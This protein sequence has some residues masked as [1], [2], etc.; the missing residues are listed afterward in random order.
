MDTRPLSGAPW[1]LIMPEGL[2]GKLN[3]HLFSGDHDEHGAVIAAGLHLALDGSV[4]LLARDLYLAIDGSDY[5]PGTRGHRMLKREFIRDRIRSC[6]DEKLVYLAVHNH[7]PGNSVAFSGVDLASHERGYPALLDIANGM[8]VG[9]LVFATQAVAGDIWLPGGSRV[10]LEGATIIGRRCEIL[11]PS[12]LAARLVAD[13]MYDR[14]ARLFGDAGQAILQGAKIAIIGLGGVGSLLAEY[15]AHLGVG[16]FLIIDPDRIAPHNRPRVVGATRWDTLFF[17]H[18]PGLPSWLNKAA[19]RWGTTKVTIAAR[20]IR[21]A[22]PSA[23]IHAIHGDV[24]EPANALALLDCDYIF[25]AA[26]TMRARLLFNQIVHQYLIPGVQVGSKVSTDTDTGEVTDVFSIVRP[27]SP[28]IGC[29]WCNQVI[30][31]AKLQEECQTEDERRAQRYVDEPDLIAP[32]VITLNAVGAAHAANDFLFYMTGLADP[33]APL[34]YLRHMART[35]I[36][37]A[38]QPRRD[39]SCSECGHETKSRLA[40]GDGPHLHTLG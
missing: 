33:E 8:P 15:L 12:P 36:S 19:L 6:R 13:P 18:H 5:V 14:Q 31:R 35:R 34:S 39:P 16:R 26:D 1:R 10:S 17:L 21:K 38:L 22:N 9:A 4:R 2:Y 29:L 40:R 23:L 28:E 11:R 7:G 20:V 3:R 24:L 27:V 32:S 37:T 25:L 30:N